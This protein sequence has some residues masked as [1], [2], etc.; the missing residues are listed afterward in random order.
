MGFCE[1]AYKRDC[2]FS[3]TIPFCKE[4]FTGKT[5]NVDMIRLY[6]LQFY[7][8]RR[9]ENDYRRDTGGISEA[10]KVGAEGGFLYVRACGG[11][12]EDL[13]TKLMYLG[14]CCEYT[15]D[16]YLQSIQA[17]HMKKGE[18]ACG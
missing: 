2:T 9:E 13:Q 4:N 16:Y 17:G 6:F 18:I 7:Y 10:S 15:K 1:G 8:K 5:G 3:G 12:G 11:D 14:I